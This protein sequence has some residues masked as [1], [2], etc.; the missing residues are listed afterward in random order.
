MAPLGRDPGGMN[1]NLETAACARC[2]NGFQ[3]K[4]KIVN[5]N[6]ELYH[7][8]AEKRIFKYHCA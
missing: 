6:G 3:A 1:M 7:S 5:S 2:D 8:Q 4:A